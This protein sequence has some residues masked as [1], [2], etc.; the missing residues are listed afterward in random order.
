MDFSNYWWQSS[1][2]P[3]GVNNSLRF[4]G[5]QWL[6]YIGDIGSGTFCTFSCWAKLGGLGRGTR[7]LFSAG[8]GQANNATLY[9]GGADILQLYANTN[10]GTLV[11][12]RTTQV[13]RDTNA[14]YHIVCNIDTLLTITRFGSMV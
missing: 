5:N 8:T 7:E 4:R 9:F 6:S 10:N 3:V 2:A 13:F 1:D 11:D 12:V 14:W